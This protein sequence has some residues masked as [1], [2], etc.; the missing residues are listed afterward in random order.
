MLVKPHELPTVD[1]ETW[2][3]L[4]VGM[5][6]EEVV[7]LIGDTRSLSRVSNSEGMESETWQYQWSDG[8]L[9]ELVAGASRRAYLVTFGAD[10]KVVSLRVPEA[11]DANNR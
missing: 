4:A 1:P 10:G 8:L 5:T 9:P 2:A 6:K 11:N 3:Q 7:S